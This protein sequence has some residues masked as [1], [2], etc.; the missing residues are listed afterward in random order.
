[1]VKETI[2]KCKEMVIT[3]E[4]GLKVGFDSKKIKDHLGKFGVVVC[5]NKMAHPWVEKLD[6]LSLVEIMSFVTIPCVT[7]CD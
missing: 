3:N 2:E 1:M 7:M 4:I 5:A 6:F